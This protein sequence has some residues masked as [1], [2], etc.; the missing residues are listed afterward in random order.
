MKKTAIIFSII[1]LVV[2]CSPKFTE[3]NDQGFGG[4]MSLNKLK[5]V[6][7][8]EKTTDVDEAITAEIQV[9]NVLESNAIAKESTSQY[10][11]CLNKKANHFRSN[12]NNK[13]RRAN[14]V[15]AK[16]TSIQ[17]A[18]LANNSDVKSNSTF[19]VFK[20]LFFIGL[21]ATSIL[22]GIALM[23]LLFGFLTFNLALIVGALP[24]LQVFSI[25]AY[26]T[27]LIGLITLIIYLMNA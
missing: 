10:S 7:Q 16:A 21:I 20:Q 22:L 4:G 3:I 27:G 2:S 26:A 19:Q 24:V 5:N 11:A 8:K 18:Q 1:I 6:P 13:K 14:L 15:F 25:C 23:M 12:L 17:K 9:K